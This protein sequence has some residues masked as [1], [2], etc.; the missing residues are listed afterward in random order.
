MTVDAT[1]DRLSPE[2]VLAYFPE[3]QGTVHSLV[4]T[5][6]RAIPDGEMMRDRAGSW[7]WRQGSDASARIA[8]YLRQ[9]GVDSGDRV[10]LVAENSCWHV[11]LLIAVSR[12][13]AI[14]APANPALGP[15]ELGYMIELAEPAL[16]LC[17]DDLLD[18]VGESA[19]AH[20]AIRTLGPELLDA[21]AVPDDFG[22]P[23]DGCVI[24]FTS[25]TTGYPKAALHSQRTLLLSG[26]GFVGRVRLQPTDR[27]LVILPLFHINA[28]FY[29]LVGALTAGATLVIEPRFSASRFWGVVE[30]NGITQT[31]MIEAIGTILLKRPDGEYR[32]NHS[33]RKIYGI[34]ESL[35]HAFR[36]R[37]G[38]PHLV[39]GYG[40]TEIP[41]VLATDYD[42]PPP[43]GS[44]GRLQN[45][46]G[47][48]RPLAE[49][50]IVEDGT[51]VPEGETGELLVRTPTVMM[52]YFRD[53][54]HTADTVVD[55]WLHTGDLVR[56]DPEG[57]FYFVARRK[58][59]IRRRGENVS[60][61]ELDRVFTAH[62]AVLL[63]TAVGVPSDM[64]DEDILLAV[65]P[66]E[67]AH[68]D[69][70]DIRRYA[71]AQLTPVKCPRYLVVRKDLP[72]TP[73]GKVAKHKLRGESSLLDDSVDL[74]D[75]PA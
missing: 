39:G 49:C 3:H 47:L 75:L 12:I 8:G 13:G 17:D 50:R 19:P 69:P 58:D 24:I 65:V 32:P 40:M 54:R 57:W 62:P 11:L 55:D 33:L 73:T 61:A 35:S 42:A 14:L 2:E 60:G 27:C 53:P 34:R 46:P 74:D 72:L 10:V 48:G 20:P 36:K 38:V 63:A 51:D 31:N 21:A 71:L 59:I 70:A 64:G 45:H 26:E 52:E 30:D 44:M 22:R 25:G 41:A 66:Q 37:F 7:T 67:G 68:I 18:N 5:R 6:V 43:A 15:A 56:K 1:A 23:E 16:I 4:E 28:I 9:Q 29:S